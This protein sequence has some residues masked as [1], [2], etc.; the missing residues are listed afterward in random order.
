MFVTPALAERAPR[1]VQR[2]NVRRVHIIRAKH[3]IHVRAQTSEKVMR[4]ALCSMAGVSEKG[5][6]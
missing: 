4:D 5:A 1:R 6:G 3:G 2:T